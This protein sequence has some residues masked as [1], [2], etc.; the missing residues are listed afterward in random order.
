MRKLLS[1]LAIVL[2]LA[3]PLAANAT[4]LGTGDLDVSHSGPTGGGYYLDYDGTVATSNFGY[5]INN[6]EVFCVSEE[7][8]NDGDYAFYTITSDL[9]TDFLFSDTGLY[10]KMATAAWVGDNW[11]TWGTSDTIKGEAQK[12]V[13]KLI[14]AM[15]I[16]GGSGTDYDIFMAAKD[17][18]DYLTNSWYY[19]YSPAVEGEYDYQNFITPVPEPATMLLLG[20]GLLGLAVLGRKKFFK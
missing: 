11:T 13:W 17:H 16:T 12:A 19:A 14:G 1:L 5:Y 2:F 3:I 10:A 18:T 4:L 6:A 20:S 9:D 8:G 7:A 15:D